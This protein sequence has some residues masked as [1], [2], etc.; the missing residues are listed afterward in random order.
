MQ[1][2]RAGAPAKLP[3]MAI[4]GDYATLVSR[5]DRFRSPRGHV[6]HGSE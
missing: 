3:I 1:G 4:A 5:I 2:R 6:R